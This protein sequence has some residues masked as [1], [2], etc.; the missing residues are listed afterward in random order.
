M[1]NYLR[2]GRISK[3]SFS[4]TGSPWLLTRSFR[5]SFWRKYSSSAALYRVPLPCLQR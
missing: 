1:A 4:H 2:G 3:G 5:P